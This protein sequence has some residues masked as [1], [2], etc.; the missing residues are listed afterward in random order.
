MDQDRKEMYA[1]LAKVKAYAQEEITH[2]NHHLRALLGCKSC[3]KQ[4]EAFHL[5]KKQ[6]AQE[7]AAFCV[8]HMNALLNN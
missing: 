1:A 6:Q 4:E 5:R 2:H 3:Q 8:T 7:V